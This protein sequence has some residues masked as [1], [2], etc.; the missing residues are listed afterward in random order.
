LQAGLQL[1]DED[2]VPSRE[3]LRKYGN[4]SSPSILF[5]MKE[6]LATREVQKDEYV[7]AVAFGPG[8]TME[9]ALLKGA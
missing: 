9:V 4:M 3:V 6:L 2:M 1:S 8:L 7:C 5:V